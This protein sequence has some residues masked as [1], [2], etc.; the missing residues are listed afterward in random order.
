MRLTR[1]SPDLD[2]RGCPVHEKCRFGGAAL[3]FALALPFLVTLLL[4]ALELG[5]L[6]EVRQILDNAVREGGRQAAA[7]QLTNSQIQ[8]VVTN[9]L[10]DAGLPTPNV[11][12][13]VA[14]LN[15]PGTEVSTANQFDP[16]QIVATIPSADVRWL[17]AAVFSNAGTLLTAQ[18]IW[19]SLVN[20]TYPTGISVPA[21][22]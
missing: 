20:Q 7:G 15:S 3:E 4:G 11:S 10:K 12:V 6:L 5:R 8:D 17:N 2:A 9:Y 22:S 19:P 14:N 18:A 21:G 13:T 1:G 16:L